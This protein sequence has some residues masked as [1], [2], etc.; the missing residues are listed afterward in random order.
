MRPEVQ[1]LYSS[2]VAT[3]DEVLAIHSPTILRGVEVM[4]DRPDGD[5]GTIEQGTTFF[6]NTSYDNA[7][8]AIGTVLDLVDAVCRPTGPPPV[9]F[10]ICRPPGHHAVV[11]QSMGFCL[12]N[13][14]A[15]A[16]RYA[17]QAHG[18]QRVMI[19]DFDVH[20]GMLFWQDLYHHH[21]VV[22]SGNGT[23]DIFEH[24]PSVLFVSTHQQGIY[25]F[26]GKL[27]DTGKGDGEGATMHIPLPGTLWDVP[28]TFTHHDVAQVTVVKLP[29]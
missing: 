15:V 17:Q 7:L 12:F 6:T 29:F 14:A 11:D 19:I 23:S 18:M 9:A 16:A 20:A 26:Q 13:T 25:P 10:G 27:E 3:V 24:D 1:Q 8:A 2:R 4:S 21:H 5:V 22:V 28:A